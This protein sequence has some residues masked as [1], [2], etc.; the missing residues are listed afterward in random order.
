MRAKDTLQDKADRSVRPPGRPLHVRESLRYTS[1]TMS[2]TRDALDTLRKT[3]RTFFIPI[4]RL[5]GSV[6]D[7]VGSAYLCMRAIDEIEDHDALQDAA[8][9]ELL[10]G[11]SAI[12]EAAAAAGR[13][14]RKALRELFKPY[15]ASLP[16]VTL[17]L[18][19]YAKMAPASIAR[20]VWSATAGMSRQMAHWVDKDFTI[21]TEQDLDDYTYDV[22]GRVGELL[23]DIW[24]WYDGTE[25]DRT[26]GIGFGRCLQ[27]VNIVRNRKED[28]S[29]GVDFYPSDWTSDDLHHYIRRQAGLADAYLDQLPPGPVREFCR[30]PLLLAKAT[31]ETLVSGGAKLSRR[32]VIEIVGPGK[33]VPLAE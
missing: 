29:R 4:V 8:K 13:L 6:R 1:R 20:Q 15:R 22:A 28:L 25:A 23:T 31:L 14:D 11:I 9:V 24:K 3:S 32:D 10:T 2:L 26:L 7:A 17:L 30:I 12:L 16:A 18:G 5:P 19:R 21:R 27:A 33:G